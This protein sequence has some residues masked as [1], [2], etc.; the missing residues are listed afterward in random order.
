VP[1][2][3]DRLQGAWRVAGRQTVGRAAALA[4]R[5]LVFE[6]DHFTL[7]AGRGEVPGIVRAGRME[8]T[9]RLGPGNPPRIDLVDGTWG[10]QGIYALQGNKL[11]LCVSHAD[12][13]ERPVNFNPMPGGE[14]LLLLL[15]RQ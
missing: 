7:A 9:F 1:S 5:R 13:P 3:R 8:G 14:Q 10:L 6:G 4:D 12:R 11:T 2:D 15:E